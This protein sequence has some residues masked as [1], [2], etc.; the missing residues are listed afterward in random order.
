MGK[1]EAGCDRIDAFVEW[2]KALQLTGPKVC[3][4]LIIFLPR[5]KVISN[6]EHRRKAYTNGEEDGGTTERRLPDVHRI[7]VMGASRG[8]VCSLATIVWIVCAGRVSAFPA[9]AAFA[10]GFVRTSASRRG[11]CAEMHTVARTAKRSSVLSLQ[12]QASPTLP[13]LE[14]VK[15]TRDLA[16]VTGSP[17]AHILVLAK[18]A[19]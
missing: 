6:S 7:A 12:A 18:E 15:N 11:A 3:F 14:C 9:P 19:W 8:M 13:N 2:T 1:L 4:P 10:A 17:G 5:T 16:S